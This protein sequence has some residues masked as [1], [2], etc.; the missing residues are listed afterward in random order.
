MKIGIDVDDVLADFMNCFLKYYNKTYDTKFKRENFKSFS[1]W[2]TIGGTREI[3]TEIIKDFFKSEYFDSMDMVKGSQ[4][5]VKKLSK[6]NE[7][8]VVT[9]RPL[10]IYNETVDWLDKYFPNEFSSIEFSKDWIGKPNNKWRK[11]DICLAKNIDVL[12]EDNIAY[13]RGCAKEGI[14]VK[15]FDCPWNQ[16]KIRSAK[17]NRV[18]CWEDAVGSLTIPYTKR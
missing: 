3:S 6:N 1:L 13:A 7:L 16:E 11:K 5:G 14:E 18:Y 15:L 2:K 8:I 12:F 9:S 4:Y 17:I 10:K